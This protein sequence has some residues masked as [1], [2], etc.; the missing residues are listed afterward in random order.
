MSPIKLLV[1]LF[2]V[3]GALTSPWIGLAGWILLGIDGTLDQ[4]REREALRDPSASSGRS[5][6]GPGR[7]RG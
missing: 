3:V 1:T 2:I 7:C 4:R 6:R 5:P